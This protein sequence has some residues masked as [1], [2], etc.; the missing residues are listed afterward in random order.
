MTSKCTMMFLLMLTMQLD[1][2]VSLMPAS[3][4]VDAAKSAARAQ[5]EEQAAQVTTVNASEAAPDPNIIVIPLDKQY[6]PVTKN[7]KTVM[8]KTAHFGKIY[9]GSPPQEFRVIFDTGSGHFFIPSTDCPAN[10]C[11]KHRGYDRQSS[12]TAIDLDHDGNVADPEKQRDKVEIEFGTGEVAGEFVWDVT[13][14]QDHR[15]EQNFTDSRDCTM[16]RVITATS[17]SE[18]PF[19]AFG[20]DGVVGLGLSDLAVHEDF[21]FFGQVAKQH[22]LSQARF[23]VFLSMDDEVPSEISFG[24]HDVRRVAHE[25]SWVELENPEYGYWQVTLVKVTVGGEPFALCDGYCTAIVDTGT[26]LLG[27][28]KQELTNF[29]WLLARR[30][31][32][33]PAELDCRNFPGPEI[34]F[35]FE[36]GFNISVGPE[37]YS[38]PAALKIKDSNKNETQVICRSSLLPVAMPG[39]EETGRTWI[40]GEPVLKK[41]Y[42]TYDWANQRVGFSLAVQPPK[43]DSKRHI[44]HG[45]STAGSKVP[46]PS[47]VEI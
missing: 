19:Q 12:L 17:M 4:A 39:E 30:V 46:E 13:C 26:S 35:H 31:I 3:S 33:E 40:L 37:D 6:V 43:T 20:F 23:G 36:D 10:T 42:T 16:V 27:V 28:P 8:Y 32:D 11:K 29:H 25:P 14:L 5:A 18:E 45:E 21:S 1:V 22:R 15:G 7:N 47:V 9:V 44:I 38:R 34:V 41:Y 24:G 2:G